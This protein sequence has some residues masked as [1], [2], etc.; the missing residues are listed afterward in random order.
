MVYQLHFL[1]IPDA[2]SDDELTAV[3]ISHTYNIL[4]LTSR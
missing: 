3:G 2:L 1:A 4:R